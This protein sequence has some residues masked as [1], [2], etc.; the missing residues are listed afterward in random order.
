[1]PCVWKH[2]FGIDCPFC[3]F[4]RAVIALLQGDI[5]KSITLFPALLP[6]SV[7]GLLFLIYYFFSVPK[8]K[9]TLTILLIVD[10]LI[11]FAHCI[12]KNIIHYCC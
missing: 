9:K 10:L 5:W 1:M 3:G 8:L 12:F 4:Q 6:L 2:Y 11:L 7:T